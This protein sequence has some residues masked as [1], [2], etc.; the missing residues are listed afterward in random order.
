M[1]H[2]GGRLTDFKFAIL[3]LLVVAAASSTAQPDREPEGPPAPGG[4]TVEGDNDPI[5]YPDEVVA[6][7]HDFNATTGPPLWY[8]DP[9]SLD[10]AKAS[11]WCK[12]ATYKA[13]VTE[14][15]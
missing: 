3:A 9:A 15:A 11:E 8:E 14:A 6:P 7:P 5:I 4:E 12:T 10:C 1:G 13:D 2:R